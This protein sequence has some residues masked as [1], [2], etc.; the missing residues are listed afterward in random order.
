[1]AYRD[2]YLDLAP[3]CRDKYGWPLMRITFKWHENDIRLWQYISKQIDRLAEG[4]WSLIS[5]IRRR[6]RTASLMM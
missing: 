6:F 5:I 1:M 3:D 2:A 4:P